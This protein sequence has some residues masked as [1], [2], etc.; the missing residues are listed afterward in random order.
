MCLN[1]KGDS[2]VL[3]CVLFLAS[4]PGLWSGAAE[5]CGNTERFS[6]VYLPVWMLLLESGLSAATSSQVCAQRRAL[7]VLVSFLLLSVSV[8]T[9][10]SRTGP[11]S[12]RWSSQ[13]T[14]KS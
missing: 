5:T 10:I 13:K 7:T 11:S 12:S 14:N 1:T 9:A 6:L 3:V 8:V 4:C 2:A